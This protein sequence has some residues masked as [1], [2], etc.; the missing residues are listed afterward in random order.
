MVAEQ[1]VPTCTFAHM[2]VHRYP[3]AHTYIQSNHICMDAY[4]NTALIHA[5]PHVGADQPS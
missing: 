4:V 3:H 5:H 2:S 1:D